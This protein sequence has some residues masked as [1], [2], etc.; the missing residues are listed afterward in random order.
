MAV[1]LKRWLPEVSGSE[2]PR[3]SFGDTTRVPNLSPEE[4]AALVARNAAA[5]AAALDHD[6]AFPAED[7]S[8]LREHGL[9][10]APLPPR[11]GGAG[12]GTTLEGAKPLLSVNAC[13]MT[14]F[15]PTS[16]TRTEMPDTPSAGSTARLPFSS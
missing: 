13:A 12:L 11:L 1:E 6:G 9:L 2:Q 8:A 3:V 4:A 10:A 16:T 14:R 7:I 15:V 5:H